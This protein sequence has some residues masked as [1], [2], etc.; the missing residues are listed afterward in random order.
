MKLAFLIS[1]ALAPSS[2]SGQALFHPREGIFGGMTG[3]H[4]RAVHDMSVLLRNFLPSLESLSDDV[5][6]IGCK[7]E[8]H[9]RLNDRDED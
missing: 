9:C 7:E 3:N 6:T 8:D 1:L 4:K 5:G 2:G